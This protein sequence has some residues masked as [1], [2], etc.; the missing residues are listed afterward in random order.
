MFRFES[1]KITSK[2]FDLK[3]RKSVKGSV[4]YL[5]KMNSFIS[6]VPKK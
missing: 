4:Q 5:P 2:R 3:K 1:L 6:V